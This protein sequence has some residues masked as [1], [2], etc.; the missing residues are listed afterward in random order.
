[1][2]Y[3]LA[4]V[5]MIGLGGFL[6]WVMGPAVLK[7]M[8]IDKS[9]LQASADYQVDS[10]RCKTK[11]FIIANCNID[12]VRVSDNEKIDLSYLILGRMGSESVYP[13]TTAN[14]SYVTTNVGVDYAGNRVMMLILMSGGLFLMGIAAIVK[15]VREK[16]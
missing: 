10:A 6:L 15:M 9:T 8:Q 16:N 5:V 14:G 3:I 11:V 4:A 12:L 2:K 13:M 1:M 7:D